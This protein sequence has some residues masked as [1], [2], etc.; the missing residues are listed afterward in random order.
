MTTWPSVVKARCTAVAL[1]LAVFA[2]PAIGRGEEAPPGPA[3][4]A[5][6]EGTV[7]RIEGDLAVVD[8]G[9]VDGIERGDRVTL[10]QV[11]KGK[12]VAIG[13]ARVVRVADEECRVGL[14]RLAKGAVRPGDIVVAV[15]TG[16]AET[17]DAE[18]P[19][20]PAVLPPPSAPPAPPAVRALE[21]AAPPPARPAQTLPRVAHDPLSRTVEGTP[22]QVSL[23]VIA[24]PPLAGATLFYRV[25]RARDFAEMAM[26]RTGDAGWTAT[27]PGREVR[28]ATVSYY[29]RGTDPDGRNVTVFAGPRQPWKVSVDSRGARAGGRRAG[30][31]GTF[32]WQEMY[33]QRPNTDTF[34]RAE[35]G[36]EYKAQRGAFHAIRAGFG[37]VEGVGGE[38]DLVEADA[39][40][41]RPHRA[42]SYAWVE[43]VFHFGRYVRWT[44][45]VMLGSVA[46]Y[47]GDPIG[48]QPLFQR[49]EVIGG[50][51]S[52]LEFGPE[53]V[54]SI[55]LK[56]SFLVPIGTEL[57]IITTIQAGQGFQ[58]GLSVGTTS[59]PMHADWAGQ[60]MLMG[61]WHGLEWLSLDVKVGVNVRSTR[62]AGLGGG[63][64]LSFW[65]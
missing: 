30:V 6:L 41:Q 4:G 14:R 50:A 26:E 40:F 18:A 37:A 15:P 8:L 22:L 55:G 52:L 53:D 46:T 57:A 62:H 32:E 38:S 17:S 54:F 39:Y 61:G 20:S 34:W 23:V 48:N 27:V 51:S 11:V 16:W 60:V 36:F 47:S 63:L 21:V 56:G 2:I 42:V 64:G 3:H 1:I 19:D 58:M 7:E 9:A 44:P 33:L 10:F 59:Y 29:V 13:E 28:D 45:R 12:R 24:D 31:I 43:P 25:G 65:W 35:L 5:A 49:G